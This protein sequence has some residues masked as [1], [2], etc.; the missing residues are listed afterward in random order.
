MFSLSRFC[1]EHKQQKFAEPEVQTSNL[2]MVD[3][4]KKCYV[5]GE[6]SNCTARTHLFTITAHEKK[7]TKTN[8]II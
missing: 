4:T 3:W 7:A 8:H 1:V 6:K 2:F 5:V